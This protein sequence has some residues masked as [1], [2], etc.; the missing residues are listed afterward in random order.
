MPTKIKKSYSLNL[1]E[2]TN[3]K[4]PIDFVGGNK[5]P[6]KENES[7]TVFFLFGASFLFSFFNTPKQRFPN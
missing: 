7:G 4:L 3:K 6:Q 2:N 1:L 5:K